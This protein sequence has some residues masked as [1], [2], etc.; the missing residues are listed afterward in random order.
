M[1][2]LRFMFGSNPWAER[3]AWSNLPTNYYY[4]IIPKF[5]VCQNSHLQCSSG[6]ETEGEGW[7]TGQRGA[8]SLMLHFDLV[9]HMVHSSTSKT[10]LKSTRSL[11]VT[12]G[13]SHTPTQDRKAFQSANGKW[14]RQ[15]SKGVHCDS[16]IPRCVIISLMEHPQRKC[17]APNSLLV[18]LSWI[19]GTSI[20]ILSFTFTFF[21]AFILRGV[22]MENVCNAATSLYQPTLPCAGYTQPYN[23]I[24]RN[25][26]MWIRNIFFFKLLKNVF[27]FSI[28]HRCHF[29]LMR[30]SKFCPWVVIHTG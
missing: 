18:V 2:P 3:W 30:T 22:T 4:W 21:Y 24:S 7:H 10:A 13:E 11:W 26:K 8:H 16:P 29:L 20:H 14:W 6:H 9:H 17:Y 1:F 23:R 12:E 27:S 15:L 28:L 25:K 5:L 19:K